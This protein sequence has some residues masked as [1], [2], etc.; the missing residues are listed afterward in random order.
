MDKAAHPWLATYEHLNRDWQQVP[1]IPDCTLS[2]Y[3]RAHARDLGDREALVYA[4]QGITY[5]QLD[6][7]AD[8]L[9]H[10]LRDQGLTRQDVLG[11]QLPNIPQLVLAIVAAARLGV[12]VTT[13]APLLTAPEVKQQARDAGI[14][15]LITLD[16]LYP[17]SVAPV[18]DELPE[19]EQVLVTRATDMPGAAPDTPF[20]AEAPV[21]VSDRLSPRGPRRWA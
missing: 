13:I 2:G 14:K 7:L 8:Q 11:I 6:Q 1:A 21:P 9:A 3:V 15:A 5:A 12:T 19:L 18:L 10:W 16:N 17:E 4:G 20:E